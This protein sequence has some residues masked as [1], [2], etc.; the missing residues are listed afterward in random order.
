VSAGLPEEPARAREAGWHVPHDVLAS[1]A[2]GRVDDV[3]A[4]SVESHLGDCAPCRNALSAQVDGERLARNRATVLALV[5][6]P[7]PGRL[8]RVL[9]RCGVP[10]HVLRLLA[11]TP[12]LRRSW[13]LS[14]LAILALVTGEA[15]LARWWVPG[16][17]GHP[18]VAHV[19]YESLHSVL[20]FL[21]VGPLLVLASVAVA[22]LPLFDPSYR[23]TVA[24][25]FS[26]FTLLLVRTASAVAVT[27][28]PVV[29]AAFV[30]PGPAWLPVALL[31]PSLALCAVALAAGRAF[32]PVRAAFGAGVVWVAAVLVVTASRSPL[33][34]VGWFT[35]VLCAGILLAAAMALYA[36]RDRFEL[37]WA[38]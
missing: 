17:A 9:G 4:W 19:R 21:L 34:V 18:G 35:Q 38:R 32:D 13:L 20:P 29:C 25:P 28:V 37:G 33:Q 31:L 16:H 23:L 24:A 22:Y 30:V 27:V 15:A 11:A 36:S 8:A 14:V 6:Q 2:V 26:G 3:D 7:E 5:A 10:E 1:Y 12:S